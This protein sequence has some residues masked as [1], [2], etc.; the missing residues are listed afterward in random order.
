MAQAIYE[1]PKDLILQHTTI[2]HQFRYSVKVYDLGFYI[3]SEQRNL[4]GDGGKNEGW[5]LIDIT[6][7]NTP[8]KVKV[9]FK[10]KLALHKDEGYRILKSIDFRVKK[11]LKT[12]KYIL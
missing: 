12:L 3:K 1:V 2:K 11:D 5:S 4:S 9:F 8:E 10:Q 6:T 7:R